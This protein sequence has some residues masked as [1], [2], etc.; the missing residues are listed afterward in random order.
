MMKLRFMLV[1]LLLLFMACLDSSYPFDTVEGP[2]D[3]TYTLA[4]GGTVEVIVT[5]SYMGLVRTLVDAQEE[6]AG[7]HT[8]TWDLM[9]DDGEYPEN[10]LYNVEIYLDGDRM[11]VQVLEVNR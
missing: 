9:D 5:D 11:E 3:I 7:A 10:G 1:T 4:A 6:E 8:V 2:V